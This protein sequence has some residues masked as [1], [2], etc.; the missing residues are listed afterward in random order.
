MD[1]YP[2]LLAAPGESQGDYFPTAVGE[3]D[4]W[5]VEYGY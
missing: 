5:A 4:R 1:Y 3:F 2:P